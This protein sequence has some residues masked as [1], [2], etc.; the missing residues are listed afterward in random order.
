[1]KAAGPGF[2]CGFGK[3]VTF[4]FFVSQIRDVAVLIDQLYASETLISPTKEFSPK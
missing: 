3:M 4:S 1:M 2:V